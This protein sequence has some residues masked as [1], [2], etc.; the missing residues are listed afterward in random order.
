[1]YKLEKFDELV[2]CFEKLP[3]IGKKNAQKYAYHVALQDS[4]LGLNLAHNIEDAIR[5]LKHCSMC[6]GISQNEICDIC[7]DDDRDRQILCVVENPKD[8]FTIEQSNSFE[9]LYF[10]FDDIDKIENLKNNVKTNKIK[11][12]LFAF[13]PGLKS[14]G[15]MLFIENELIEFDL[16]FSKIAQGIP[17][18]VS[19]E[20]IDMLSLAKAIKN[21]NNA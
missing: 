8:I 17:V 15:L 5:F 1:M 20:N 11:E 9:G 6:G 4:F 14:D 19:L 10:V 18:G 16:S 21:K 12:I 13:T 7:N 2:A 3:G